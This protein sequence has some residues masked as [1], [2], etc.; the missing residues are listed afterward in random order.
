MPRVKPVEAQG[1]ILKTMKGGVRMIK[2]I[3][4]DQLTI[5]MY[6]HDLN[7]GW[8]DHSFLKNQFKVEDAAILRKINDTRVL[9]LYID[10]VLGID[11]V[12]ASSTDDEPDK[13]PCDEIEEPLPEISGYAP[14]ILSISSHAE[15]VAHARILFTDT[16]KLVNSMMSD[17]RIGKQVNLEQCEPMVEKIIDSIFRFPSAL[18]PLAQV[19]TR[20]EYTFQHSV[21]VSALAV[22]FGRVLELP[23]DEIKELAMGGLLHDVGKAL[24]PGKILNK[25]GK[26]SDD[27]FAIMKGHVNHGIVLLRKTKGIGEI[28]FDA[29]AQHHERYD[30]SGYPNGLKGEQISLYGQMLAIVDVYDD[31]T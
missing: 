17:A 22:T 23:R 11:V 21:A 1:S 13:E 18:L 28:A 25:P 20:D 3:S 26:L 16:N 4:I 7:C 15:E 9:E 8:L 6:V 5:G 31:V 29:V 30:G 14:F 24:V 12:T 27:E 10:T 19:K 2:K